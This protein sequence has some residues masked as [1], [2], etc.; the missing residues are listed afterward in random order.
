MLGVLQ[1]LFVVRVEVVGCLA[2]I[3]CGQIRSCW[4]SGGHY[5]F[6]RV[7]VLLGVWQ[8]LFVVRVEVVGCLAGIICGQIRSYWLSGGHYLWAK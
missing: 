3:A 4:V 2:G 8:A 6:V 1:A 5:L 7:E